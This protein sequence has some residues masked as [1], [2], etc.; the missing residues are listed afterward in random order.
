MQAG[1]GSKDTWVCQR[2]PVSTFS[3]LPPRQ[4]RR[5]SCRAAAATCRA[6]WPT[7]CTGWAATP[8]GPKASPAWAGCMA[9]AAGRAGRAQPDGGAP[10]WRRCCGRWPPR[11]SCADGRRPRR[12]RSAQRASRAEEQLLAALFDAERAGSLAAVRPAGAAGGAHGARP[13]LDRH[14]A[15]ADRA[16][17]RAGAPAPSAGRRTAGPAVPAARRAALDRTVLTLAAFSG[18]AM[19]S[20]TRGQAWRFLDM[21]RR[22]ERATTL[23][24]ADAAAPW[25]SPARA[26]PRCWRPSW[27]S[28]TA[29]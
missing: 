2:G 15:G 6:A 26:R 18:L 12:S 21:G 19:D 16:G 1:A 23:V 20:M 22:L 4:P 11:P 27:T 8:S 10:S 13:H 17:R 7:T 5:S 29:A 24:P 3:L 9:R 28:P 14:L 25:S